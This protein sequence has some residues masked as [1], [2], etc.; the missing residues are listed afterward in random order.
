MSHI[1]EDPSSC[2]L[3]KGCDGNIK[4]KNNLITCRQAFQFSISKRGSS[5]G[6]GSQGRREIVMDSGSQG[7]KKVGLLSCRLVEGSLN[8]WRWSRMK[9]DKDG[10]GIG[11]M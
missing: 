3:G 2:Q 4:G 7:W 6:E 10:D 9:V 1:R 5:V 11:Q 8:G